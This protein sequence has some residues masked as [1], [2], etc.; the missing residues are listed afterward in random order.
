MTTGRI[1]Q[2]AFLRTTPARGRT[3]P[4]AP[5]GAGGTEWP[6]A[7]DRSRISRAGLRAAAGLAR[8]RRA[9]AAARRPHAHH[10]TQGP[11]TPQRRHPIHR[12]RIARW[13]TENPTD[14]REPSV[15]YSG[16]RSWPTL[17]RTRAALVRE[18]RRSSVQGQNGHHSTSCAQTAQLY[19]P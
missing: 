6:N 4:T 1:N 12:I 5:R 16:R 10:R 19:P 2:V 7:D 14:A 17:R 13:R 3:A 15:G 11:N 9:R 18:S 8:K